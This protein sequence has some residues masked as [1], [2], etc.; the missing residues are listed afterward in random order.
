MAGKQNQFDD[1]NDIIN[2][3][4]LVISSI[5]VGL[6]ICKFSF[7]GLDTPALIIL[8]SYLIKNAFCII[9]SEE[10]YSIMDYITPVASTVIFAVLLYFVL[11]MSYIRAAIEEESLASY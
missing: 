2:I 8:S 11:E 6:F 3:V 4:T 9:V 7:A 10:L 1:L 5:A